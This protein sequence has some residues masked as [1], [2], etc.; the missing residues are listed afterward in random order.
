MPRRKQL[1]WAIERMLAEDNA[2]PIIFYQPGGTCLRPHV[3]GTHLM[4]NSI[5]NSWRM[6]DFWL[7][8]QP[9]KPRSRQ[10][11]RYAIAADMPASSAAGTVLTSCA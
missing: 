5:F 9:D 10:P 1:L 11:P 7:E 6:E 8:K 2:R 4:V 3:K